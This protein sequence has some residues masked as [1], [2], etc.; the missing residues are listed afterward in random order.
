MAS[1]PKATL[2]RIQ[3]PRLRG[4]STSKE[5]QCARPRNFHRKSLK[6]SFIV[7]GIRVKVPNPLVAVVVLLKNLVIHLLTVDFLFFGLVLQQVQA[8]VAFL[9]SKGI[10]LMDR[11]FFQARRQRRLGLQLQILWHFFSNCGRFLF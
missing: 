5:R 6:R 1:A 11:G 2:L 4:S 9:T 10:L 8:T 3:A 7:E